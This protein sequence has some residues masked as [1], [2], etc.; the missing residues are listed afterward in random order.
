MDLAEAG[1]V[2]AGESLQFVGTDADFGWSVTRGPAGVTWRR[3]LQPAHVTVRGPAL[4]LLL[5]LNRRLP[6][7]TAGVEISGDRELVAHWLSNSRF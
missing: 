3:G 6:V 7:E 4:R 5:L 2:G 1:L